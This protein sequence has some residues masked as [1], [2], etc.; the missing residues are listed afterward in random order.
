MGTYPGYCSYDELQCE[1]VYLDETCE[2]ID[3]IAD[4]DKPREAVTA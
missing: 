3:E 1:D 4:A 2:E